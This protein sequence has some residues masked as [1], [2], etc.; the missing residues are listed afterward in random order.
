MSKSD[1]ALAAA[2][3]PVW[4]AFGIGWRP[5]AASLWLLAITLAL[6]VM[7]ELGVR[8][9]WI[10]PFFFGQPSEVVAFLVVSTL[11]G[12]L[13]YNAGVTLWAQVLGLALGTVVGTVIGL[14]LWWS[15]FWARVSE[16]YAVILNATP[17]IVI[18]PLLIVW[19]GLG[20]F[21]KVMI[22]ALICFVV[23]WLGAFE[24]MRRVDPDQVDLM[25]SLGAKRPRI[26]RVIVVPSA[27]PDLFATLRLN[28]GFALIG[29][30]TGEFLS[31]TAGLGYLVDR[32]AKMYEMSHTLGAIVAI[33]VLAALQL[34]LATRAE[35]HLIRWTDD[36][37][38]APK[39]Q[40]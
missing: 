16:P 4:P 34:S 37:P 3:Q 24:A 28:I 8:F 25:R 31:S 19:F 7:W 23:A 35:R 27:L 21:S 38:A 40:V 20:I 36:L 30:I 14:G 18:A 29:V 1:A 39:A 11:N 9:G 17:K 26:F 32:T 10:D 2:R 15:P 13:L 6:L 22:A 5:S 33:A 12:S